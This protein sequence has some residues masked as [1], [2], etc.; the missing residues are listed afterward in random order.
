MPSVRAILRQHYRKIGRKGGH[1]RAAAL[2]PN[3]RARIAATAAA[4]RWAP[5][6]AARRRP[7]ETR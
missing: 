3:V 2:A 5:A 4:A 7:H 6:R 1:A